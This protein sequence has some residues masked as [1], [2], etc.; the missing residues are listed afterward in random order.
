MYPI[1]YWKQLYFLEMAIGQ[2]SKKGQVKVW[3]MSPIFKGRPMSNISESIRIKMTTM[4]TYAY[5]DCPS[6][7]FS[8]KNDQSFPID[9]IEW[10]YDWNEFSGVGYGSA[11]GTACVLSYYCSLMALTVYYFIQSFNTVLPWSVCNPEWEV[12][13][14][15]C[16]DNGTAVESSYNKSIP[17]LYFKWAHHNILQS[18]L[19]TVIKS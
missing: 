9:L 13:N 4:Y 11:F 8:G 17:E 14:V 7:N 1:Y 18:T 6:G 15:T 19:A 5:Y 16:L 12:H 3:K 2:F 10:F